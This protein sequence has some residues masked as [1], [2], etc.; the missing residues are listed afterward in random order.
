MKHSP[1]SGIKLSD[2]TIKQIVSLYNIGLSSIKIASQ[3]NISIYSVTKYLKQHGLRSNYYKTQDKLDKT[4]NI[5]GSLLVIKKHAYNKKHEQTI[6]ECKCECG[7]ITYVSS[8]SLNNR[9]TKSCGCLKSKRLK[10]KKP[11]NVLEGRQ[12]NITALFS[13]Y[14]KSARNRGYSFELIKPEFMTLISKPC[15]YCGAAPRTVYRKPETNEPLVFN[16]IDR[17]D[18]TKGY[19]VKNSVTCCKFCNFAK[20]RLTK[21]EFFD[22]I[23]N[24]YEHNNLKDRKKR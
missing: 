18:N 7:K 10:G 3:L 11:R 13:N 21:T 23:T 15:A 20:G 8:A 9:T 16:G 2:E 19:T 24:I 1:K 6:W 12:S 17:V 22:L 14:R 5:Y 4:G